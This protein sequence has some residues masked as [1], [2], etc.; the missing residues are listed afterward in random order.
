MTTAEGIFCGGIAG[1]INCILV[2]PSELIKCRLQI[3]SS[4]SQN[5]NKHIYDMIFKILK[6]ENFKGLY[7]GNVATILREIPAYAFQFGGYSYAKKFFAKS[8]NKKVEELYNS[9]LMI[10]GAIGGYFCWQFSYPQDMVKTLIQTQ[11]F[12][13]KARLYDGGFYECCKFIYRKYG[14]M[15]FWRG[16]LPCSLRALLSNAVLFLTYENIKYIIKKSKS[17]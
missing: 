17:K 8:E 6:E 12:H 14:Y 3:L 4:P 11:N 9:R 16:F 15:G 7:K 2:T 5:S 13:F 10:C 1:L